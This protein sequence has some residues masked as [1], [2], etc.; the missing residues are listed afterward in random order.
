VENEAKTVIDPKTNVNYTI[1][2]S[3]GV[4]T[5]SYDLVSCEG[6][7]EWGETS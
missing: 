7:R 2:G 3:Y 1:W 4:K 6:N 5:F